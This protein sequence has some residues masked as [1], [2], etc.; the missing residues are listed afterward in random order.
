MWLFVSMKFKILITSFLIVFG[1]LDAYSQNYDCKWLMGGGCDTEDP[2]LDVVVMDFEHKNFNIAGDSKIDKVNFLSSNVSIC[3]EEGELVLYS[4]GNNIYNSSHE[5]IENGADLFKE[6]ECLGITTP[7]G[8]L[9][10]PIHNEASKFMILSLE[11]TFTEEVSDNYSTKEHFY[12]IVDIS[13]NEGSGKVVSR[14]EI[15]YNE[16]TMTASL[17]ACKHANGRDWWFLQF[18]RDSLSLFNLILMS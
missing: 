15:F 11:T 14:K 4:N 6:E 9:I 16:H 10:L 13:L 7:Q 2:N 8:I 1:A 3:N 18:N 12:S 17:S 5:I